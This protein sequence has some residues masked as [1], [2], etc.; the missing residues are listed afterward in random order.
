MA[1]KLTD[2]QDVIGVPRIQQQCSHSV[3]K[4]KLILINLN[5]SNLAIRDG[6]NATVHLDNQNSL[7]L[8]PSK[9]IHT[10]RVL[11]HVL[12]IDG[13]DCQRPVGHHDVVL[14]QR[15]D[16]R[17]SANK[18]PGWGCLKFDQLAWAKHRGHCWLI[19][20]IRFV[21]IQFNNESCHGKRD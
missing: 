15:K 6:Q 8:I 19:V 20:Y 4:L 3:S 5:Q 14:I 1:D 9:I 21:I 13:P 2:G 7:V 17:N 12:D 16:I 18:R 11:S 10:W